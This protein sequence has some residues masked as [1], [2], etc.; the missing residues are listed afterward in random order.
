M[1]DGIF[2]PTVVLVSHP[3][4]GSCFKRMEDRVFMGFRQ[5]DK[6]RRIVGTP[7]QPD[8]VRLCVLRWGLLLKRA[9]TQ[10]LSR[11]L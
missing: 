9:S 5:G 11:P 2:S 4:I 10:S 8:F 6:G 7:L 3:V 1:R